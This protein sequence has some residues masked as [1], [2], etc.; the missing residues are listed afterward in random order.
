MGMVCGIGRGGS[1]RDAVRQASYRRR[2]PDHRDADEAKQECS[3]PPRPGLGRR[4][5]R[6]EADLLTRGSPHSA[7][8]RRCRIAKPSIE[9]HLRLARPEGELLQSIASQ[10]ERPSM[11]DRCTVAPD[12]GRRT[13]AA[14]VG[15]RNATQGAAAESDATRGHCEAQSWGRRICKRDDIGDM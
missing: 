14:G 7:A 4:L 6:N 10:S 8:Q 1:K 3:S 12:G 11:H 5:R 15:Q 9:A 2:W 13:G